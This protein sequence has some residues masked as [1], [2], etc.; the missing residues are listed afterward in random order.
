MEG[1][2][3]RA[4]QGEKGR[5]GRRRGLGGTAAS[6]AHTQPQVGNAGQ[7]Y[8]GEEQSFPVAP[9]GTLV[10]QGTQTLSDHTQLQRDQESRLMSKALLG[11]PRAHQWETI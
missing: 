11:R 6:V 3:A 7:H 10:L 1:G 2:W 5:R 9:G 4:A 8:H